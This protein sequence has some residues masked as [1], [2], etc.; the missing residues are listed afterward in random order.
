MIINKAVEWG[1]RDILVKVF[2][3]TVLGDP[4]VVKHRDIQP[5]IRGVGEI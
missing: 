1:Y 4:P 3:G 2:L 5:P